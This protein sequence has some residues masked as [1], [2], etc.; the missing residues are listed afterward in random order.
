MGV[1]LIWR[2]YNFILLSGI[3][4]LYFVDRVEGI[5]VEMFGK[6]VDLAKPLGCLPNFPKI[7]LISRLILSMV[8]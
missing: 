8:L 1:S 3:T 5:Q 4:T 2:V 6:V 7:P